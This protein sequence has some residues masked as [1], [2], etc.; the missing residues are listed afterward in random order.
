M[1]KSNQGGSVGDQGFDALRR[2][3][4]HGAPPPSISQ[5]AFDGDD[6]HLRRLV[7]LEANSKPRAA[8]L[9]DYAHDIRYEAVQKDLLLWMLPFCLRTWSD[10]LRGQDASYVGF[11]EQLYPALCGEILDRVLSE[12]EAAAVA[13][14]MREVLLEEIDAQRGLAFRG[15]NARPYR[16]VYALTSYGV[17]HPDMEHL[18]D[19]WWRVET[20]GRAVAMLQ[21]VSCLAYGEDENPVFAPWTRDEG[22][23][24][25]C[26]WEFAGH[27]YTH[28]WREPN[29]Q[30]LRRRLE[31]ARISEQLGVAVQRLATEEEGEQARQVQAGIKERADILARRCA[32]L[33]DILAENREP[34]AL[35]SWS[36]PG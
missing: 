28:R 8:D 20:R 26:L 13:R 19:A 11:V 25:P 10:D 27:L 31:P 30:F 32:E 15:M 9:G 7:R 24:P 21:Y 33:P 14:F 4:G 23:G 36:A 34:S 17:L 29:V 16:W 35:R 22:G 5:R 2:A 12:D 3:L 6:G 1:R 18:W